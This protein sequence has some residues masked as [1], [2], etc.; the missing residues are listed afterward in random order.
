MIIQASRIRVGG[1]GSIDLVIKTC[2]WV[3][4]RAVNGGCANS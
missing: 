4:K 1:V 2:S 3:P